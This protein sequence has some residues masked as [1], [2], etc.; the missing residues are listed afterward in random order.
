MG[1]GGGTTLSFLP[2]PECS[3]RTCIS[4]F[5]RRS[6]S[7]GFP[8]LETGAILTGLFQFQ[9]R[10]LFCC[11]GLLSTCFLSP[12]H[13]SLKHLPAAACLLLLPQLFL[14]LVRCFYNRNLPM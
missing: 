2:L 6:S 5:R 9:A 12:S 8:S 7:T 11:S 13:W 10:S 3:S 4:P 14:I 1:W